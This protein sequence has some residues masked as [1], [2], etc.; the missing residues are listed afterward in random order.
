MEGG[1]GEAIVD[2]LLRRVPMEVAAPF[3]EARVEE[4]ERSVSGLR[5]WTCRCCSPSTRA[6]CCSPRK[7]SRTPSPLAGR[8]VYRCD[9]KP[10]TS[11][12]FVPV[13]REFCG[14]LSAAR[15]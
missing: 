8:R 7:A 6:A 5:P 13:L 1:Y 15:A 14:T 10:S 2:E 4:G 11:A 3:Y 9:E 12:E